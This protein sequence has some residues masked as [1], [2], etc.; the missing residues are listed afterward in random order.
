MNFS[1]IRYLLLLISLFFCSCGESVTEKKSSRTVL[2]EESKQELIK[3]LEQ[4]FDDDQNDRVKVM[5]IINDEGMESPR[6]K[7]LGQKIAKTDSVNILRVKEIIKQYGWLGQNTV[8]EKAS[9]AL[10]LVIQHSDVKTRTKFLPELRKAVKEKNANPMNLAKLEDRVALEGGGKQKYGT[11]LG[12]ND[13]N[14]YYLLPLEDPDSVDIYR[15]EI[16]LEPISQYLINW[17]IN[18]EKEKVRLKQTSGSSN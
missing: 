12:R 9:D 6:V 16:G 1:E 15:S 5:S 2:T 14:G 11:Q 10:F 8:G 13:D 17:Q 18:W 3:E 7:E 4:I